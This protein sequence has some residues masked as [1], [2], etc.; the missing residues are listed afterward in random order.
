MRTINT[1]VAGILACLALPAV[2][3]GDPIYVDADATGAND[4]TSWQDAYTS[5]SVVLGSASSGM[6]VWVAEGT[7]GPINNVDFNG[8]KL[9]GGFHGNESNASQSNPTTYVTKLSGNGTTRAL[10][11]TNDTSG[12][13]IRGFHIVNG[14]NP[15][16]QPGAGVLLTNS[17]PTFVQCV[18]RDNLFTYTGGAV[19]NVGTGCPRFINCRFYHNGGNP[20]GEPEDQNI[21]GL[22]GGA[23]YN[24]KGS[25]MFVNCL[26]YENTAMEAGAIASATGV[27][28]LI[29][30][31]VADNIATVGNGGALYDYNGKAVI[32]NCV[33]WNNNSEKYA[34]NEIF[35]ATNTG[36]T[37]ITYSDIKGGWTGTGNINADPKFL[38]PG[39]DNYK[40]GGPFN[41]P[42]PCKDT[43]HDPSVPADFADLDWDGITTDAFPFDLTAEMSRF[44]WSGV[45]MGA[46][47]WTPSQQ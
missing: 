36:T 24:D 34:S 17:S 12:T 29:N 16:L 37:T 4:G 21:K 14:R 18:F 19:A 15:S 46:Y 25:P 6:E 28:T 39:A 5:L 33:F 27:V 41:H 9:Y 20:N 8:V 32:K 47:E 7:Y 22:S 38:N 11:S 45:D 23:V 10:V 42:S 35:N 30:C 44:S 2:S 3:A 1:P 26:F 31:T 40:I 43:G 13:V